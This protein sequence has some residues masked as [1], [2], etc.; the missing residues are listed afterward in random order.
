MYTHKKVV[1]LDQY[2][3]RKPGNIL[4]LVSLHFI[5]THQGLVLLILINHS[6]H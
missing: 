4:S 3:S 6:R 5:I 1:Y 2:S